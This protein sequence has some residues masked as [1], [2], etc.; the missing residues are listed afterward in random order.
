M[1]HALSK[2]GSSQEIAEIRRLLDEYEQKG[3]I[4]GGLYDDDLGTRT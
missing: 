1:M 2:R 3:A 4:E